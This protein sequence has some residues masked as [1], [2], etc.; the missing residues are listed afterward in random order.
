M[1]EAGVTGLTLMISDTLEV[2]R[3]LSDQDWD[4]ESG[5]DGWSVKDLV[6]HLAAT[7]TVVIDPVNALDGV[8]AEVSLEAINDV[9]VS[10]GADMSPAEVLESYTSQK[11]DALAAVTAVQGPDFAEARAVLGD[12]GEYQVGWFANAL[13]FD[14]L[15]H[16]HH[17]VL[18]PSGPVKLSAPPLDEARLGPSLDWLI[19]V[20]PQ[21]S[22]APLAAALTAPVDVTFTGLAPKQFQLRPT[23]ADIVEVVLGASGAGASITSDAL[24]A[25]GWLTGRT[26]KSLHTKLG[27]DTELAARVLAELK[28]V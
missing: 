17:D 27:G 22:K 24:D 26:D 15:C 1:S 12:V 4:A 11:D 18:A 23:G 20:I 2:L 6:N 9:M 28:A 14:H 10:A 5:C 19:E 21:W 8:T 25:I 7:F 16:L 13:C 3:Q